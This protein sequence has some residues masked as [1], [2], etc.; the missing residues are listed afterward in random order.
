MRKAFPSPPRTSSS[1]S[2][3]G[4]RTPALV[5]EDDELT[6]DEAEVLALEEEFEEMR[7]A[8]LPPATEAEQQAFVSMRLSDIVFIGTLAEGRLAPGMYLPILWF[9]CS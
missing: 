3:D 4:E 6:Q 2:E 8:Q 9:V 7:L 1:S 5:P